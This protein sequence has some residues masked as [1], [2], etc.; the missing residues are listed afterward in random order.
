MVRVAVVGMGLMGM[1]HARIFQHLR[2]VEVIGAIDIDPDRRAEAERTLRV[3]AFRS[4]DE[5]LDSAD[6]VSVTLPDHLHVKASCL[7]LQQGKHV[8]VE[9]PLATT[10]E[11]ATEILAA[12]TAPHR[13]MV[14]HLLRF[15]LR[16]LELKRR[17]DGGTLGEIQY[18]R[19]HRANTRGGIRRLGGRAS[20]TA[21][22]GVHD[23]DLMLWLTGASITRVAAR[24]RKIF[25]GQWDLSVAHVDL[26][27]GALAVVENHWLI[28]DA[29]SRSCLAGIQVFG[30][31][32]T[33]AVD[34]STDELELA[35]DELGMSR[36]IDSRNWTHDGGITG[37]SLRRELEVFVE[38]I[39]AGTPMPVPGADGLRAVAAL[40]LVEKALDSDKAVRADPIV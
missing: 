17:I 37:G 32:G 36:R 18:F 23:L 14:G 27:T 22:L 26:S 12:Q 8:L 30:S 2:D 4:L 31:R 24:G 33:A 5:V 38:A 35:T 7:A 25:S 39:R 19:I 13:L 6:A 10:V 21:F 3:P 11:D 20:V 34:L 15:D 1:L 28:H 29:A 16:L 40:N 9:K